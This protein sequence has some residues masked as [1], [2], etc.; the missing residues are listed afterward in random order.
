MGLDRKPRGAPQPEQRER[1]GEVKNVG[2]PGQPEPAKKDQKR[3]SPAPSESSASRADSQSEREPVT[4]DTR[5]AHN[6]DNGAG[7]SAGAA[8]NVYATKPNARG[9][10]LTG[11]PTNRPAAGVARAAEV[12]GGGG[13]GASGPSGLLNVNP[14][15][16]MSEACDA[17][18]P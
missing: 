11:S 9:H 6:V 5:I 16:E 4:A 8:A 1:D 7:G 13:A 12:V 14:E 18:W 2:Q 15:M 3:H 17:S 10:E